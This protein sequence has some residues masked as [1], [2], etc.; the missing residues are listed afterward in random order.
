MV[1][2]SENTLMKK[3]PRCKLP[4]EESSECRYCGLIFEESGK[5]SP[6]STS[7]KTKH[8][9]QFVWVALILA[10]IAAFFAFDRYHSAARLPDRNPAIDLKSNNPAPI[11]ENDKLR[12]AAKGLS[13]YDG[14]VTDLA[15]GST[16]GSVIAMI[17]FSILG[18]GYLSYGKKSQ[19][20]L[21]VICGIALMGYPYFVDGTL[22]I[23]LIGIG[24][25]ILPFVLARN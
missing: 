5:F 24:L 10:I 3:C 21:M 16:K 2:D 23:I 17:I 25:G 8:A 22:Y 18:L 9:K 20:L 19:Q 15:S 14:I 11:S 1:F 13:G 12:N 7:G 6:N 4:Q